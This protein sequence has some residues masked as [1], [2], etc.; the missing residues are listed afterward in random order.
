MKPQDY[1]LETAYRMRLEL[2][3]QGWI[4]GQAPIVNSQP[5]GAGYNR[6]GVCGH[7][8]F[9]TP[10]FVHQFVRE[11]GNDACTRALM[12]SVRGNHCPGSWSGVSRNSRCDFMLGG[13]FLVIIGFTN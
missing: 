2:S 11:A 7:P 12:S 9:Q 1:I 8:Q 4:Q 3:R 10:R 6:G 13:A 5:K